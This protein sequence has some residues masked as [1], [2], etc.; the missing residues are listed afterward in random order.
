MDTRELVRLDTLAKSL[1]AGRPIDA[2]VGYDNRNARL[3]VHLRAPTRSRE[4]TPTL[5]DHGDLEGYVRRQVAEFVA[6]M[7]D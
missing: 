5:M 4:C 2:A 3:S 1:V 7:D 6:H